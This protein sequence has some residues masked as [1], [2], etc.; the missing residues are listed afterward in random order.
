M[1]RWFDAHPYSTD[2]NAYSNTG[3]NTD[4]DSRP[5]MQRAS[6]LDRRRDLYRRAAR[7]PERRHL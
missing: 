4:A 5:G 2:A 7:E 6:G 3:A 1:R